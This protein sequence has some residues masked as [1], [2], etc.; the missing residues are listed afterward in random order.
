MN[1]IGR[2]SIANVYLCRHKETNEPFAMKSMM[3]DQISD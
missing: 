2:G 3:K 1:L